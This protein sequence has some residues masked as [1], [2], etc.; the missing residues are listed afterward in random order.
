M[1][2]S[3]FNNPSV[4]T[5]GQVHHHRPPAPQSGQVLTE[6][7]RQTPLMRDFPKPGGLP[8]PS[9]ESRVFGLQKSLVACGQQCSKE[10]HHH[11]IAVFRCKRKRSL[12]RIPDTGACT[13]E[14][15]KLSGGVIMH[16]SSQVHL[17]AR[18]CHRT[19]PTEQRE[20]IVASSGPWAPNLAI[21]RQVKTFRRV[22]LQSTS[23]WCLFKRGP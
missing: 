2:E 6:T 9:A 20:M 21:M 3:R 22:G 23:A 19:S 17:T 11:P 12:H 4:T 8:I 5:K 1:G 13:F 7:N 16:S 10:V 18:V 15:V 14:F